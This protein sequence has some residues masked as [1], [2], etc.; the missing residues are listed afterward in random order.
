MN[1]ERRKR[2]EE[3]TN[4]IDSLKGEIEDILSEEE[5]YKENIPENMQGGE[6]FEIAE[7]ACDNLQNAVDNIEEALSYLEEAQN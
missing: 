2:I 6:R 3:V 7:A 1:K 5:E 4:Q